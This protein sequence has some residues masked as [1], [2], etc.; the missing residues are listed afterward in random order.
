MKKTDIILMAMAPMRGKEFAPSQIHK[1][2]YLI[3][4]NIYHDTDW[5]SFTFVAWGY[6]PFAPE[7]PPLLM[8]LKERDYVSVSTDKGYPTYRLTVE[9]Q[10]RADELLAGI[11]EKNRDYIIRV[12]QFVHGL[13]FTELIASIYKTYPEMR[14]NSVFV[15]RG[16]NS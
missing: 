7:A 12:S 10:G 11:E 5:P 8:E 1:I 3:E 6:G 14:A 16:I 2:L 9:G 13:S 15:D 4:R